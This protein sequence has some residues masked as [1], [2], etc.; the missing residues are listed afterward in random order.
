M[1][2]ARCARGRQQLRSISSGA[3][4][5]PTQARVVVAGGGIIGT[6]VAYHLAKLGWGNDVLLLEKD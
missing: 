6:S 4:P 2:L 1:R 5:L 3:A